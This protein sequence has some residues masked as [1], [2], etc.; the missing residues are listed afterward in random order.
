LIS[1]I[2]KAA[3]AYHL[4]MLTP[5]GNLQ[6]PSPRL[7][8]SI[9]SLASWGEIWS[10]L[11]RLVADKSDASQWILVLRNF[12]VFAVISDGRDEIVVKDCSMCNLL[13]SAL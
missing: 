3:E 4:S 11:R 9:V 10:R 6:R 2:T 1:D 5:S 7:F 8:L 12:G 13:V